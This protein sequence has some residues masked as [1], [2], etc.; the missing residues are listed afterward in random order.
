MAAAG[1]GWLLRDV[2]GDVVSLP[3]WPVGW[4]PLGPC[5]LTMRGIWETL[6]VAWLLKA[7]VGIFLLEAGGWTAILHLN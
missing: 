3:L 4:V 5:P 7:E 1:K 2:V 6:G